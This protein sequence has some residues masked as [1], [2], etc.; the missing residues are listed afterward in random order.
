MNYTNEQFTALAPYEDN[1]RTAVEGDWTRR[2]PLAGQQ[3]IRSTYEAA[4][5]TRIPLNAGCSLCLI[6]LLKRAGRLWFADKKERETNKEALDAAIVAEEERA[7]EKTAEPGTK[8]EDQVGTK[9]EKP[10]EP[11]KP[12]AKSAPAPQAKIPSNHHRN[13]TKSG[14]K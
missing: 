9:S 10:L 14:K 3:I 11:A 8:S 6:N 13:R 5:K 2:V 12:A 4:T 1:F 7:S